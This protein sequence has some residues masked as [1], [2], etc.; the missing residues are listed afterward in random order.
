MTKH[1]KGSHTWTKYDNFL[2]QQKTTR[3]CSKL[4][5]WDIVGEIMSTKIAITINVNKVNSQIKSKYSLFVFK[6]ENKIQKYVV[7]KKQS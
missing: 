3:K 2:S 1:L 5:I 6:N 4:K 7:F